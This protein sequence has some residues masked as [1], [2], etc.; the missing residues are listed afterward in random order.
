MLDLDEDFISLGPAPEAERESAATNAVSAAVD[1]AVDTIGLGY[2]APKV[3]VK[4]SWESWEHPWYD[5]NQHIRSQSL[6]LHNEI[7]ELTTLLKSTAEEDKQRRDAVASVEA[8][9]PL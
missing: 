6:R 8:V 5:A 7:V 9:R 4:A 3:E 1:G 2:V